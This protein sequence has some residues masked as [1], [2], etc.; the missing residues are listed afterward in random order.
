M[1]NMCGVLGG[2]GKSN[3][4]QRQEDT[5]LGEDVERKSD[6][7]RRVVIF[8]LGRSK[9]KRVLRFTFRLKL[10]LA[11]LFISSN[12]LSIDHYSP[13]PEPKASWSVHPMIWL[14]E[15]ISVTIHQI[16]IIKYRARRKSC[17]SRAN[18]PTSLP[19]P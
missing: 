7:V 12:T 11:D 6:V 19:L 17:S 4:Q 15:C 3:K 2:K 13:C 14:F 5:P 9:R 18:Y 8:C 1:M 10:R 16:F